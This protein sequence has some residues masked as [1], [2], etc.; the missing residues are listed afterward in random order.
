[1]KEVGR[2]PGN[3]MVLESR[4]EVSRQFRHGCR[5]AAGRLLDQATT[6]SLAVTPQPIIFSTLLKVLFA[7]HPMNHLHPVVDS[8]R[9][10]F[11]S[12][13]DASP[14]PNLPPKYERGRVGAV[15]DAPPF[16]RASTLFALHISSE[17]AFGFVFPT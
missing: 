12:A 14:W 17:I 8:R 5:D 4:S 3:V 6:L 2:R 16:A 9:R 10:L 11:R 15:V 13:T 7:H 1:M